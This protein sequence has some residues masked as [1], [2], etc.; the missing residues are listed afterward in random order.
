[1]KEGRKPECPIK[2]P[3]IV[4]WLLDVPSTSV[5]KRRIPLDSCVH[6]HTETQVANTC[7]LTYLQYTDAEPTSPSTDPVVPDIMQDGL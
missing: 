4:G 6:I 1:M 2:P 3:M 7:C 5:F